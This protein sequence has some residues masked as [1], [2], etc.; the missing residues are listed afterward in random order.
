MHV[1]ISVLKSTLETLMSHMRAHKIRYTGGY[2]R[3]V[4]LVIALSLITSM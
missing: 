2:L 4:K 1:L 3:Y